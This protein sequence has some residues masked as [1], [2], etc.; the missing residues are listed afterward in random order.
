M[1]AII[2]E[3]E[4]PAAKRLQKLLSELANWSIEIVEFLDSIEDT[5]AWL[6]KNEHPDLMFL[7]I[8]LADGLS[9]KILEKIQPHSQ[10]IFTTAYDQYAVKAFR[11]R[12]IDYLLKPIDKGELNDAVERVRN[13]ILPV[14]RFEGLLDS[15]IS[16]RKRTYRE[17]F[18]IRIGQ[19][20]KVVPV[21][22]VNYFFSDRSSTYLVTSSANKLLLDES[23]DAIELQLDPKLYYRINRKVIVRNSGIDKISSYTNSRLKLELLPPLNEDIVVAR[24]RVKDFKS[25]LGA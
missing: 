17:R 14:E 9:F 22:E 12:A 15:Y 20:F 6:S 24:E 2:V 8:R 5:I 1:K 7:D 13:A 19:Q 16:E 23:L 21:S 3:D 25:W 10:I 4:M 11:A 18:L